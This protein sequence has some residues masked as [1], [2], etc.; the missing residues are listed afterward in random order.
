[1]HWWFAVAGEL[2]TRGEVL[3]DDWKYRPGISPVDLDDYAC[4]PC[5]GASTEALRAFGDELDVEA[6]R[7][8]AKGKDY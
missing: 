5:A 1:M 7:L 2:Y 4:M 6:R 3:P 8:K